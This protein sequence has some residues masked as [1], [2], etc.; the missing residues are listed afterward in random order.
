MSKKILT[1]LFASTLVLGACG[2]DNTE[3]EEQKEVTDEEEVVSED[4]DNEA[5]D[6]ESSENEVSDSYFDNGN[7]EYEI[8]EIEQIEGEYDT[9]V[10]AVE[11]EFTNNTDEPYSPWMAQGI[12]A[13]QET[14]NTIELLDG[15]NGLF[16][17]DYKPELV[18]MGDSDIKPG[19]TVNA[20]I[21]FEIQFPG[22]EVIL[23]D[24]GMDGEL[25]E[26]VVDTN[27]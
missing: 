3:T 18:K 27:E 21:G 10:L 16:P 19:K 25:F 7:F 4:I 23:K 11:L 9:D 17:E 6:S 26:K 22:S 14:E 20:V 13:E 12:K 5:D 8:K 1:L 2:G 15:A 24:F